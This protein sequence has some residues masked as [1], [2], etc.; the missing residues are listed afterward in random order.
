L[1]SRISTLS[2]GLG[3]ALVELVRIGR[4][5]LA[6]PLEIALGAAELL[7][8]AVLAAWRFVFPVAVRAYR[9]LSDA[10]W[11][12]RI[13]IRPAHG[14]LAVGA[15]AA[16]AL[17]ASQFLDYR[18]TSVGTDAY[19]GVRDVAPAPEIDRAEAGSA[20]GWVMIPIALA[21][22]GLLTASVLGRW[23]A[24]RLLL[25]LGIAVVAISLI[26][27]APKGLDEG[28]AAL[29][30]E[31]A[32]SELLAGFWAQLVAGATLALIGPMLSSYRRPR[33]AGT[34]SDPPDGHR[35]RWRRERAAIASSPVPEPPIK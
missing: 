21:A 22:L 11:W 16:V 10:M 25:P 31:S 7:G 24:P 34:P 1:V 9:L 15:A 32:Q 26:V 27:D 23:R 20:H 30:Y 35:G 2:R 17:G 19:S 29:S 14:V 33:L 8:A 3:R 4:E 28:S 18:G 12:G 5:M 13:H 6:I